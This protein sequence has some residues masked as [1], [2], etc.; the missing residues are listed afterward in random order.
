VLGFKQLRDKVGDAVV[1]DCV[2]NEH[3][4]P[5]TGDTVQ[6]TSKGTFLWTKADGITRYSDGAR[7]WIDGPY[8][9]QVRN[10]NERFRWE[11]GAR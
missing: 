6:R 3:A 4:D 8:G 7:T 11:L 10:N 9:L 2:E 1:G 5:R